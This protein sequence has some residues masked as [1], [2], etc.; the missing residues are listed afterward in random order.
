MNQTP[1]SSDD[2]QVDFATLLEQSFEAQDELETIERGDLVTGTIVAIDGQGLIL[3]VG[4]KRDGVVPRSDL[5]ALSD[6]CDYQVGQEITVMVIRTEDQDGSLLVSIQQAYASQDWDAARALMEKDELYS[7]EV[8]AANRGGLIVPYGQLRGFVPASHVV[9]LPRGL[10]SQARI[11]HL[12]GYIG[13]Q[14]D[15]KI[16]EVNPRRR[17]LVLSQREAQRQ[18]REQAKQHL[19]ENLS[20][21]DVVK[22]RVSSLRDFGAFVDLGGADGLVHI[23]ELSWSRIR[24]PSEVLSVGMEVET[25]ILQLD[26]ERM[27]IGLSLKRL[28]PNP[29]QEI[30]ETYSVGQVVDGTVSRVVSFGAFVELENGIEALL[31]ISQMGDPPPQTPEEAVE[32]GDHVTT[33]IISLEPERQRIG[34]S[35]RGFPAQEMAVDGPAAPDADPADEPL[36]EV[37]TV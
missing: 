31:H 25:Y 18:A 14:L 11:D 34:L 15:L 9:G 1:L 16:I 19:L 36:A 21:G 23:S 6:D 2:S 20:E 13:Q 26:H 30:A 27:R 12:S 35:L 8:V 7:G 28:Q 37:D 32:P 24:H 29:W 17:R 33:R 10:D 5:D 22:G 4:L 3:D